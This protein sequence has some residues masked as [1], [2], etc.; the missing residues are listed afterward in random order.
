[1]RY[2]ATEGLDGY[3]K[4]STDEKVTHYIIRSNG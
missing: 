3:T 1:M 2:W 4:L